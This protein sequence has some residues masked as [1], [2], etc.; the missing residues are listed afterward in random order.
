MAG[1]GEFSKRIAEIAT[2]VEEGADRLVRQV[3]LAIDA[4]VVLATPVD[5]GRARA[6][7]IASVGAPVLV[8]NMLAT[9]LTGSAAIAQAQEAVGSRRANDEVFIQNNV[10]Y[11]NRLNDGW[12]AQ[13]PANF[14]ERAVL[15]GVRVVAGASVLKKE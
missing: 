12:S 10:P 13:A 1:L 4:A 3:S 15:A 8:P 2:D 9:D 6:N 5:T 14:V 7:W 11:I